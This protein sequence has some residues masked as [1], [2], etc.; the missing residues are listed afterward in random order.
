MSEIWD[1]MDHFWLP[2]VTSRDTTKQC[3][4]E[5]TLLTLGTDASAWPFTIVF[6]MEQ[7]KGSL[8]L[9]LEKF[10]SITI[11]PEIGVYTLFVLVLNQR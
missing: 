4:S 2:D 9:G 7:D 1:L 8:V 6:L 10:I 3:L 11:T 5:Q